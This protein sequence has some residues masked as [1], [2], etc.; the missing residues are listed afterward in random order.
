MESPV[1]L[2][3]LIVGPW[4]GQLGRK[5]PCASHSHVLSDLTLTITLHVR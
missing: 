1:W 4:A 3:R 5:E 2:L